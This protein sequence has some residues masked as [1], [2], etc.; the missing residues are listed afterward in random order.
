[1]KIYKRLINIRKNYK[2]QSANA[3]ST[4]DKVL[5]KNLQMKIYTKDKLKITIFTKEKITEEYQKNIS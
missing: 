5:K 4:K 1:M 2:R 3:R